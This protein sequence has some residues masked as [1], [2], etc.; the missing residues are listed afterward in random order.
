MAGS[1]VG[2]AVPSEGASLE[3]ISIRE[4]SERCGFFRAREMSSGDRPNWV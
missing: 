4:S 2:A 1:R 3:H